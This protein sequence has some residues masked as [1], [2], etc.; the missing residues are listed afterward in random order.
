MTKKK[1]KVTTIVGEEK[2]FLV[3]KK[4]SSEHFVKE[5]VFSFFL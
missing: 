5:K 2:H 3:T 4:H 1:A